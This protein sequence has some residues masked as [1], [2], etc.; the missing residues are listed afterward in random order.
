MKTEFESWLKLAAG[1][2]IK[3]YT[4]HKS[5]IRM[6]FLLVILRIFFAVLAI[7]SAFLIFGSNFIDINKII[8]T[9]LG[10]VTIQKIA[11]EYPMFLNVVFTISG[12]LSILNCWLLKML[13]A[14]NKHVTEFYYFWDKHI[15]SGRKLLKENF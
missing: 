4:G 10:F 11:T 5:I 3:I 9:N 15:E 1:K 7:M 14:S 6:K 8:G 12:V 13:W 2:F